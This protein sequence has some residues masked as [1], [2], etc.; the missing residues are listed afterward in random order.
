M[1]GQRARVSARLASL[2]LRLTLNLPSPA[3]S[4]CADAKVPGIEQVESAYTNL[5]NTLYA[6]EAPLKSF[7]G[8]KLY[9]T[10]QYLDPRHARVGSPPL[11]DGCCSPASQSPSRPPRS[12]HMRGTFAPPIRTT[13]YLDINH[14]MY[15]PGTITTVR[16]G[17]T[18]K[19][20]VAQDAAPAAFACDDGWYAVV[21]DASRTVWQCTQQLSAFMRFPCGGRGGPA[22]CNVDH[23]AKWCGASLAT[24]L[25]THGW[26]R[27][28][29][30]M[31]AGCATPCPAGGIPSVS[32][33]VATPHQ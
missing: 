1:A 21:R 32:A 25:G 26:E 12:C 13:R 30:G 15:P 22:S 9:A 2:C 33:D 5:N 27:P 11:R 28:S 29:L 7:F 4:N 20:T 8:E 6:I 18:L 3:P 31:W 17:V 10:L 19:Y 23:A 14:L 24:L 16:D